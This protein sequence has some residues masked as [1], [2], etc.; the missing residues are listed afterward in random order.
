ML[1]RSKGMNGFDCAHEILKINPDAKIIAVSGNFIL[2]E[3]K[4]HGFIKAMKKPFRIA[5]IQTVFKELADKK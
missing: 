1:F 5:N 2:S 4:E 3:Y